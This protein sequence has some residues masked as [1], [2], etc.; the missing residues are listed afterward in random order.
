MFKTALSLV[1]LAAL[2]ACSS[3]ATSNED[4]V[5]TD[6]GDAVAITDV[7]EVGD[8]DTVLLAADDDRLLGHAHWHADTGALDMNVDARAIAVRGVMTLA[9]NDLV[10]VAELLYSIYELDSQAA[11]PSSCVGNALATCCATGGDWS[12]AA[13]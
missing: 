6:F 1:L 3:S 5:V 13:N 11:P 2:A 12:C 9:D 4:S 10:D 7:D 8:V